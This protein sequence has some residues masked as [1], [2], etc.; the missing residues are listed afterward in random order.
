MMKIVGR[1]LFD[2]MSATCYQ[3]DTPTLILI[4]IGLV[5]IRMLADSASRT[6]GK[7]TCKGGMNNVSQKIWCDYHLKPNKLSTSSSQLYTGE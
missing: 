4:I 5:I 3:F 6:K 2:Q 7:R 1:K